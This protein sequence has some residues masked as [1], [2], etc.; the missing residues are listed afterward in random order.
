MAELHLFDLFE[1]STFALLLQATVINESL[2]ERLPVEKLRFISN[3]YKNHQTG[4]GFVDGFVTDQPLS[5]M[6][7]ASPT[8]GHGSTD[9]LRRGGLLR[10]QITQRAYRSVVFQIKMPT[11]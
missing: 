6:Y 7:F 4:L 10:Y 8:D 3:V 2:I 5:E 9:P 1:C 11:E